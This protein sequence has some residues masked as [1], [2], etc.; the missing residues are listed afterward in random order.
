MDVYSTYFRSMYF[1][2]SCKVSRIANTLL[3]AAIITTGE[4]DYR[5]EGYCTSGHTTCF[6][7]GLHSVGEEYINI[8]LL[9]GNSHITSRRADMIFHS[10]LALER[11]RELIKQDHKAASRYGI[12]LY[13]C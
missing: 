6:R 12:H 9:F 13:T 4:I 3:T 11:I 2:V 7:Y 5:H 10:E 1:E 8:D